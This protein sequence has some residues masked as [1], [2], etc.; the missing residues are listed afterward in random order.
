[1]GNSKIFILFCILFRTNKVKWLLTTSMTNGDIQA[2]RKVYK[3]RTVY[4]VQSTECT[5][6]HPENL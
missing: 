4:R 3:E 5:E 2:N 6:L 1:M